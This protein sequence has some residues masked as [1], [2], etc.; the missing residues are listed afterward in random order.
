MAKHVAELSDYK[1]IHIGCVAVQGNRVL[2]TGFNSTK[3]HP[4]QAHYNRFRQFYG[5]C[6]C[7]HT[8]HAEIACLIP[9]WGCDIDWGKVDLYIYRL[10]RDIDHGLSRPCPA[11]LAAIKELGIKNVY[12]TTDD[13]YAHEKIA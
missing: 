9:L 2:S 8:L 12:Y 4:L 10:R 13:G 6:V 1:R 11:C 3:S 5:A 7:S